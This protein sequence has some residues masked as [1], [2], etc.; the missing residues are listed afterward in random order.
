MFTNSFS[1]DLDVTKSLLEIFSKHLRKYISKFL[2]IPSVIYCVDMM[3]I[4]MREKVNIFKIARLY[5]TKL[6]TKPCTSEKRKDQ[7]FRKLLTYT[8]LSH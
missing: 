4:N 7:Y 6:L 8:I 3:S 5:N 1:Y 2:L